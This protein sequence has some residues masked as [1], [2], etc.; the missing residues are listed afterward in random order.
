MSDTLNIDSIL[1]E[2]KAGSN[3]LMHIALLDSV[4]STND[5]CLQQCRE[6]RVL[7]FACVTD[8][9]TRGRGRLGNHWQSAPG[10]SITMSIAWKFEGQPD[11]MGMLSL[12]M[13]MAV[14][15]VLRAHDI[16]HAMLKWPNDVIVNHHKIAGILIETAMVDG[17]LDVVIGIGLNYDIGAVVS[18]QTESDLDS[19]SWTDFCRCLDAEALESEAV[20]GR[21]EL[22]GE[23]LNECLTMCE[24]YQHDYDAL[25][26]EFDSRYNAYIS[27][28]VN[29]RLGNG[30]VIEGI[31]LGTTKQGE[32]RVLVE[33][34]EQVFNS[35]EISLRRAVEC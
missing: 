22:I 27:A 4:D 20:T 2:M 24:R 10:A 34:D 3:P 1:Q 29:V 16:E 21:S 18:G 19:F 11:Q 8:N 14:V 28:P 6:N 13:G 25:S 23:L 9:Q 12:A 35:A 5:W 32:L 26:V 7:P 17:Q 33:E 15:D 31:S 30:K